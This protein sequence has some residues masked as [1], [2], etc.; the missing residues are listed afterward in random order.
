M[1]REEFY[2]AMGTHAGVKLSEL[3]DGVV[4]VPSP[5]SVS[6]RQNEG[7]LVTWAGLYAA[8]AGFAPLLPNTTWFMEEASAPQTDVALP[9]KPEFGGQSRYAEGGAPE[10]VAEGCGSSRSYDLGTKLE[11]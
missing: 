1:G 10:F 5:V 4:Y 2:L 7:V 3:I 8:R 11:L 6:H 9:I